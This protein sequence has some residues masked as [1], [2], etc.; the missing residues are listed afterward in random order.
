MIFV[1]VLYV[2]CSVF[3]FKMMDFCVA[4]VLME[5]EDQKSLSRRTAT[6]LEKAN[7]A[8]KQGDNQ[9]QNKQRYRALSKGIIREVRFSTD[10]RSIFDRFATDFCLI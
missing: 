7:L 6:D 2:F 3:V 8:W 1:L 9:P 10:F 4:L 5:E